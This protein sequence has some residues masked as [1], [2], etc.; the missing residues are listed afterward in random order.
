L[1]STFKYNKIFTI[2]G[3]GGNPRLANRVAT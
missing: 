1:L 3:V 2:C